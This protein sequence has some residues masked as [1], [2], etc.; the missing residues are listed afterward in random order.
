MTSIL[1]FA[2]VVLILV[3]LGRPAPSHRRPVQ[4]SHPGPRR[5]DRHHRHRTP[6]RTVLSEKPQEPS[7]VPKCKAARH[8]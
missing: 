6:R 5:P 3:A 2:I 4:R 7:G 8:D 1:V